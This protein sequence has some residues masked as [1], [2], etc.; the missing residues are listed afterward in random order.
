M[1]RIGILTHHYVKNYGAFL[2]AYAL[3]RVVGELSGEPVCL[4][5]YI[6]SYHLLRNIIHVV[7]FRRGAITASGSGSV[8]RWHD[9]TRPFPG[10]SA[11]APA[12]RSTGWGWTG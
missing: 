10:R 1:G 4:V 11:S 6:N 12:R 9:S 8:P 2:Q 5:N 3:T 7:R